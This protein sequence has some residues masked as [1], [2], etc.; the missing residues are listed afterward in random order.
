VGSLLR[1]ILVIFMVLTLTFIGADEVSAAPV[2][3][4]IDILAVNFPN[5]SQ[6]PD[7]I[8]EA[9]ANLQTKSIPYWNS[10]LGKS[11]S[12]FE[13]VFGIQEVEP[14]SSNHISN[15]DG[16]TALRFIE[17][18]KSRL[19]IRNADLDLSKRYL[20]VLIPRI[21]CVW[22]AVSKVN[23]PEE[24]SGG[25][26]LNGTSKDF[27]ISHELG[28]ALGLGHSNLMSCNLGKFDGDW[29][30]D[31][32][33]IEYGGAVDVMGN[34]DVRTSLSTYHLWRMGLLKDQDVKEVWTDEEVLLSSVSE[35]KGIRSI[36]LRDKDASYWIEFRKDSFNGVNKP[37]LV[38]YRID[39]PPAGAVISPNQDSVKE[40]FIND[41]ISTDMWL[42]NLDDYQY[43][44]GK[45]SGSMTLPLGKSFSTKSGLAK[46]HYE[47]SD[48]E[49]AKVKISWLADSVPPP[50]PEI[51]DPKS[52]LSP[53]TSILNPGVNF[54]DTDSIISFHE[55]ETFG[56]T[57]KIESFMKNFTPSPKFPL[58]PPKTVLSEDLPEGEYDLRI[59]AVD[60]W[61]NRSA[62]SNYVKVS[63][64]RS[65][66]EFKKEAFVSG[67]LGLKAKVN[68]SLSDEGSGIC[69]S[70]IYN[71][72][73]F[74][75]AKSSIADSK[76]LA[77][78]INKK[79]KGTFETFDCK[80]NG[81]RADIETTI[82]KLS[83][84]KMRKL[85]KWQITTDISGKQVGVCKGK[86][87]AS[88]TV[89]GA[90]TLF[91]GNS[92]GDVFINNKKVSNF[93]SGGSEGERVVY[94]A[95][96]VSKSATAR[97]SG[98]NLKISDAYILRTVLGETSEIRRS[99][100]H[101]DPTFSESSQGDLRDL[102][103]SFD[104]FEESWVVQV[105]AKGTTLESP[106]LDL[107]YENYDSD[108]KRVVR[109]QLQVFQN[110][111]PYLFIS[112]EA[113]KYE[114][115]VAAD[116]A[117]KEL[118]QRL[119]DCIKLGGFKNSNGDVETYEFLSLDSKG[120]KYQE[121]DNGFL[122]H[123]KIGF[124]SN[125]RWLLA[126]Y[127]FKSSYFSGLYVVKPS[128]SPF[129]P[130]ELSEWEAVRQVISARLLQK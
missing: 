128:Q 43:L 28:H 20:V 117:R 62:W 12:G 39:P 2:K 96:L 111:S 5:V 51:K 6:F 130:T 79:L 86:C 106:T 48:N 55:I 98:N 81:L 7:K 56:E 21:D 119:D 76:S 46:I 116:L 25:M 89:R 69:L 37:G 13:L 99:A 31:C 112:T 38:I 53:D 91:A 9:K 124:G 95:N 100:L 36:F 35:S 77:I 90:Y 87:S 47:T 24:W 110:G 103:F 64:D 67:V 94:S 80:G 54:Y 40:I 108:K 17:N 118:I 93:I 63:I 41:E 104:D 126:Y 8:T 59:R 30:K 127:Q 60:A 74:S 4:Y 49:K 107:C 113:V 52:W 34:V 84:S 16:N 33:G 65:F 19:K 50:A 23:R 1:K 18:I 75:V 78:P 73:G 66:P 44:S 29:L 57:R 120:I 45:A 129:S 32:R 122:M 97:L 10:I 85:G 26:V 121:I 105:L 42:I 82:S 71:S 15:C 102:G 58:N 27:V 72:T 61:G 11:N 68:F 123:V 125:A 101:V 88:F 3:R 70:R 83:V 109:R 114:S 22:E 92:S 14:I 115:A